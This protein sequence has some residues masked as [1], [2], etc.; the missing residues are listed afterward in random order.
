MLSQ[1]QEIVKIMLLLKIIGLGQAQEIVKISGTIKGLPDS[2]L[3]TIANANQTNQVLDSAYSVK[4]KFKLSAELEEPMLVQLSIAPDFTVMTFLDKSKITI[5]GDSKDLTKLIWKGSSAAT[6][7][8]AFKTQFDPIF[9][10]VVK[11]NEQI[12]QQGWNADIQN[13]IE[14]YK[15]TVRVNIDKFI[16]KRKSSPVSAFLLAATYQLVNNI[17]VTNDQ[18][19]QLT[20]SATNN[21]YGKYLREVIDAELATAIGALA[22]DFSQADTA[23]VQVS[24]SSFR[25]KYVLVD[26]W[27]SWCMPCRIENPNVVA[28]YEKFKSKN[29]TVLGVSLDRPG[30]KDKWLDAIHKDNLTWTHVSDLKFWENEVAQLYKVQSIPQNFLIDPQGKIIAKNL[31]GPALEEK[32]CEILGCEK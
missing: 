27:A 19:S 8:K 16:A 32:L 2:T 23:G 11:I 21:M 15:D 5:K 22:K 6:D 14:L 24:L 9:E 31:K 25:G 30:Q 1:A 18:Y 7:F 29:F 17:V 10:S 20:E 26:F 3:I 13:S 12:K 28:N 4:G